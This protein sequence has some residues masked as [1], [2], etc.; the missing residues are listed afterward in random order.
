MS[1]K[2]KRHAAV[3]PDV[4]AENQR[5][6]TWVL[7]ADYAVPTS[8]VWIAELGDGRHIR[9]SS[10]GHLALH[11]NDATLPAGAYSWLWEEVK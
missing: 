5:L 9:C 6:R 11:E 2:L 8:V 1:N 4:F 3:R 10:E 7:K